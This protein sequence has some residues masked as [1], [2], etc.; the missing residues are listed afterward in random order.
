LQGR[1]GILLQADIEI[2]LVCIAVMPALCGRISLRAERKAL[3]SF[4]SIS[5]GY[6]KEMLSAQDIYQT[7]RIIDR[8]TIKPV[9]CRKGELHIIDTIKH[10]RQYIGSITGE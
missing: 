4:I 8:C 9:T 10:A 7:K 5:I 1:T 3:F 2:D 6:R